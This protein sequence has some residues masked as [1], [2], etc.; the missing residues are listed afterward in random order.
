MKRHI[1]I[2]VFGRVQGVCFRACARKKATQLGL[3]GFVK[4][5]PDTSVYIEAEGEEEALQSL[6]EWAQSGPP[7]AKVIQ[8]QVEYSDLL[9]EFADFE[10]R[11]W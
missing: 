8:I 2:Q 5:M 7:A 1:T 3:N 4:N 11:I 6:V 9:R 10:I